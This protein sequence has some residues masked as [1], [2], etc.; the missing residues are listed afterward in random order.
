[1]NIRK[2]TLS[3]IF[4]IRIYY[5]YFGKMQKKLSSYWWLALCA[6]I[7]LIVWLL[8]ILEIYLFVYILIQYSW[9]QAKLSGKCHV[10]KMAALFPSGLYMFSPNKHKRSKDMIKIVLKTKWWPSAIFPI[11]PY[12]KYLH[13]G[14]SWAVG[15]GCEWL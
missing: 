12:T 1:M 5:G 11:N 4:Q 13:L 8:S 10:N 2:V 15:F 6:F 9:G 3:I 7:R 14:W